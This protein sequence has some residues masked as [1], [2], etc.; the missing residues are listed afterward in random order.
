MGMLVHYDTFYVS[1][2]AKVYNIVK[3]C[4]NYVWALRL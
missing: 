1:T 3:E 4:K 2:A